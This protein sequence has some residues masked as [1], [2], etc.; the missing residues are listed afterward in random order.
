[1]A[2]Q[3]PALP[4]TIELPASVLSRIRESDA[5]QIG[6]AKRASLAHLKPWMRPSTDN[7][8]ASHAKRLS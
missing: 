2:A 5:E 6:E 4:E 8:T 1:M 3:P 7:G